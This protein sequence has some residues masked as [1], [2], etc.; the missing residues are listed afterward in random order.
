LKRRAKLICRYAAIGQLHAFSR[1]SQTRCRR[2]PR[3]Q[4]AVVPH[5]ARRRDIILQ[6][7]IEAA[8]LTGLGGL[9]GIIFGC[10]IALLI[11]IV[12]PT[13]IP[14]WA[15]GGW[16]CRLGGLGAYVWLV[17]GVEGR[18]PEPDRSAAIRVGQLPLPVLP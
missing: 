18:A 14:L 11:Q 5:F 1:S 6:F 7:L 16:L 10:V 17:A 4:A 3:S 9:L 13:H 2:N 12:M 8:T 15:P